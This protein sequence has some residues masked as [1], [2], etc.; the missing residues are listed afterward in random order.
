MRLWGQGLRV[1][2]KLS[3]HRKIGKKNW[4]IYDLVSNLTCDRDGDSQSLG[5]QPKTYSVSQDMHQIPL[6]TDPKLENKRPPFL[7][8]G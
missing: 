1:T 8:T 2:A 3:T 7:K 6:L 5:P 4:R